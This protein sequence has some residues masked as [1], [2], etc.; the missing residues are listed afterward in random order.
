MSLMIKYNT[1][2]AG[3]HA[4][5]VKKS[6]MCTKMCALMGLSWTIITNVTANNTGIMGFCLTHPTA[7]SLGKVVDLGI[8]TSITD[9]TK[10]EWGYVL[11][12]QLGCYKGM[13]MI[14]GNSLY[15][16]LIVKKVCIVE[17]VQ[18]SY[19][20][21]RYHDYILSVQPSCI[22]APGHPD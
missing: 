14:D 22:I 15:R 6:L 12:P 3:L 1:R 19:G 10:F 13:V 8:N 7:L 5:M 20:V 9:D 11:E 21:G 4:W 18:A 2:D 16:L 17:L